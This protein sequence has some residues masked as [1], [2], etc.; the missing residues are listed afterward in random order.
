MQWEKEERTDKAK[1]STRGKEK[2]K[3]K[4]EEEEREEDVGIVG[5]QDT[6][7]GNAEHHPTRGKERE[8]ERMEDREQ[9]SKERA[10]H[11]V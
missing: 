8:E 6:S 1:V 2:G 4:E 10:T 11:A 9:D 7:H 3:T 5:S